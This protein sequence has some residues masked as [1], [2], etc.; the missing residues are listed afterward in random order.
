MGTLRLEAFLCF[1]IKHV[2]VDSLFWPSIPFEFGDIQVDRREPDSFSW[3]AEGA[4][5]MSDGSLFFE[6][7]AISV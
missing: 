3:I 4:R 5:E 1:P 7:Y 2:P 6:C